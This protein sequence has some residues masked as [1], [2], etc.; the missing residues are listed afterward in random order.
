MIKQQRHTLHRTRANLG[1]ANLPTL[2]AL[3][4]SRYMST[5]LY[6]MFFFGLIK[7]RVRF[8]VTTF[9][10]YYVEPYGPLDS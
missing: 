7:F 6:A 5:S 9:G 4:M 3:P 8:P 1:A 10:K 2:C